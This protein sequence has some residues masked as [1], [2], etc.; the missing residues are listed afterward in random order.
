MK[1]SVS[2]IAWTHGERLEAYALLQRFGISGLEIAPGVSRE[3]L[4]EKT[5]C[6]LKCG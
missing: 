5:A 4:Q 3:E 2:N 1:L 6:E